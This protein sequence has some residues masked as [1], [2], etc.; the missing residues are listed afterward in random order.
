MQQ[1]RS[2]MLIFF[3]NFFEFTVALQFCTH[4]SVCLAQD[5]KVL[6]T[7]MNLLYYVRMHVFV[8]H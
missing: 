6:Q 1:A 7:E 2:D 5:K 4:F 3:P 8:C